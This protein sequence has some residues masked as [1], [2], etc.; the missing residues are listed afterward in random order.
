MD[1]EEVRVLSTTKYV[2]T[3]LDYIAEI[4][5][6]K[7]VKKEFSLGSAKVKNKAGSNG[8]YVIGSNS[9]TITLA[10]ECPIMVRNGR[11]ELPEGVQI[12][13]AS[14]IKMLDEA[15]SRK[16][17]ARLDQKYWDEIKK[18][19]ESWNFKKPKNL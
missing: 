7:W 9:Q 6:F 15:R 10:W 8:Y 12:C 13:S 16:A 11:Q 5:L 18:K 4:V 19:K 1:K 2:G 14:E 3:P 17:G